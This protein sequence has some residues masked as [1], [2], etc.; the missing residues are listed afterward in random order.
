V[1]RGQNVSFPNRCL[2][3]RS[4][5]WQ[6]LNDAADALQ[7]REA[8]RATQGTAFPSASLAISVLESGQFFSD[9]HGRT[10]ECAS[11]VPPRAVRG[12]SH[13]NL[14]HSLASPPHCEFG[15]LALFVWVKV[16][17]HFAPG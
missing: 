3:R 9:P 2:P 16:F 15:H 14:G 6:R 1:A 5:Y 8:A 12:R 10:G 17:R 13:L 7:T 11:A 4:R